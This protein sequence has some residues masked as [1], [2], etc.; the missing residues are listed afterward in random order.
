MKGLI[1]WNLREVDQLLISGNLR[2]GLEPLFGKKNKPAT[3]E[4]RIK[5]MRL[6]SSHFLGLDQLS[7]TR[8][9]SSAL[10]TLFWGRVPL[11]K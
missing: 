10:F 4:F 2:F 11:L 1:Q 5:F 9:P 3:S 8:S 6:D 7:D